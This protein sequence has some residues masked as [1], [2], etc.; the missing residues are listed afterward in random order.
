MDGRHVRLPDT[1]CGPIPRL[2]TPS[3]TDDAPMLLLL[4]YASNA[5]DDGL[6]NDQLASLRL[7]LV[8]P[9][10]CYDLA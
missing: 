4:P 6:D 8:D 1:L 7:K 9:V 2:D 3:L 5:C 10:L